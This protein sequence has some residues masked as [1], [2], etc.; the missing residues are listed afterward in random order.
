MIMLTP[1]STNTK[2]IDHHLPSWALVCSVLVASLVFLLALAYPSYSNGQDV[3]PN[4]G[5]IVSEETT[6]ESL[7]SGLEVHT[8]TTIEEV[9]TEQTKSVTTS[10]FV[11]NPG[12]EASTNT[13][14]APNWNT[15]GSV[16]VGDTCGPAGGNCLQTGNQSTGGGTAAQ[17]VNLFDK[18]T[19]SEINQGFTIKYG[20]DVGSDSSNLGVPLCSETGFQSDCKD[21]FSI[22]LGI[23]DSNGTLLHKFEHVFDDI[24][25][26]GYRKFFFTQT[27][28]EN[29]YTSAFATLELF[30]MDQG[31]YGGNFGPTF[32]NTLIETTF[33]QTQLIV[34]QITTITEELVATAI[35]T[36]TDSASTTSETLDLS[37]PTV[38]TVETEM[39]IAPIE[40][41]EVQVTDSMGGMESFEVTVDS[42]MEITIEPIADMNGAGTVETVAETVE[43]VEAEV[44]TQVAEVTENVSDSSEPASASSNES[45]EDKA[46]GGTSEPKSE[47]KSESKSEPKTKEEAKREIAQKIVQNIVARLGDS[48][49][50]QAT[51]VALMNLVSA[52]ITANQPVLQDNS[53]WYQS[54]TVY[55]NQAVTN[56]SMA[57]YFMFGGSSARLNQIINQQYK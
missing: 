9:T 2:T 48:A 25:F 54:T 27:I 50:D 51:Q 33:D 22:T 57:Q 42:N 38:E 4:G 28:E 19:Q 21:Q 16:V 37:E 10:N 46:E 44:E 49:Q 26:S 14:T 34:S 12:F 29:N 32:D 20:A 36:L 5:T 17:T 1:M 11:K 30:G 3:G 35:D 41:F 56:N 45:S 53:S 31:F 8:T 55:D 43:S 7:G 40:V 13:T 39:E 23:T 15:S 47:P 24:N 18:M 6:V 52:D